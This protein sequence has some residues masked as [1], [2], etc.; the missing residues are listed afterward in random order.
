M[1]ALPEQQAEQ[2]A[3]PRKLVNKRKKRAAQRAE[4]DRQLDTLKGSLAARADPALC[5][6]EHRLLAG[7]APEGAECAK[8]STSLVGSAAALCWTCKVALCSDCTGWLRSSPL[9]PSTSQ[10]ALGKETRPPP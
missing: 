7:E 5:P 3:Q 8:C 1:S 2:P 9:S 4:L 10:V 6:K